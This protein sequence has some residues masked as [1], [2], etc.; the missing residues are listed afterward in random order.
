MGVT[1]SRALTFLCVVG[2][3]VFFR[4]DSFSAAKA[5][6]IGMLGRNGA[7]L[8][9]Q[10]VDALPFLGMFVSGEGTCTAIGRRNCHGQYRTI[11]APVFLPIRSLCSEEPVP[12]ELPA[13]D[14][15]CSDDLR[16]YAPAGSLWMEYI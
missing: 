14:V 7:V 4:A 8:P 2:G 13:P 1:F 6:L 5:V 15:A 11:R 3:W 12:G 10:I 16:L 9:S